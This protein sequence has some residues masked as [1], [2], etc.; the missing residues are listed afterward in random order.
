MLCRHCGV[1][2]GTL[3]CT[4]CRDTAYCSSACQLVAWKQGHK[5]LCR[6]K[7][8]TKPLTPIPPL[9]PPFVRMSPA[10]EREARAKESWGLACQCVYIL[11]H[12]YAGSNHP[13]LYYAIPNPSALELVTENLHI[14]DKCAPLDFPH[15]DTEILYEITIL[16]GRKAMRYRAV[17]PTPPDFFAANER[18]CDIGPPYRVSEE[19]CNRTAGGI[20]HSFA[21]QIF[22]MP[23]MW[24]CANITCIPT[25]FLKEPNA[26]RKAV[27]GSKLVFRT[28]KAALEDIWAPCCHDEEC[29]TIVQTM[30]TNAMEKAR[31]K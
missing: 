5:E 19:L 9:N 28:R 17:V 18:S 30:L 3:V 22:G 12:R 15:A 26:P 24:K 10:E 16:S 4:G 29:V 27:V 13:H 20:Q 25:L 23:E 7:I 1:K 21:K 11:D 31:N 8:S 2:D 14:S 6:G